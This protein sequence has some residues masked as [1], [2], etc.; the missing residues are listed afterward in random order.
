MY[1]RELAYAIDARQVNGNGQ[2]ATHQGF[3]SQLRQGAARR[4]AGTRL[5]AA[6]FYEVSGRAVDRS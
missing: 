1:S 5:V 4:E 2:S 3:R 6:D